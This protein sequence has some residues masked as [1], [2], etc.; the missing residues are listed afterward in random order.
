[1]TPYHSV[2]TGFVDDAAECPN[3]NKIKQ[4]FLCEHGPIMVGI[5]GTDMLVA[6]TT[7]VFNELIGIPCDSNHAVVLVGWDDDVGAW[8]IKN[9][10]GSDWGEEGYGW[11][12]RRRQQHRALGP[13]GRGQ[14]PGLHS[15]GPLHQAGA[16]VPAAQAGT[17][18][19]EA[20][21]TLSATG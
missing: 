13:V 16:R 1:M 2:A 9:S 10:W 12:G 4:A 15:A 14:E 19:L 7:G 5:Y 6:N 17:G 3:V 20:G 11:G 21:H 8:L 18:A